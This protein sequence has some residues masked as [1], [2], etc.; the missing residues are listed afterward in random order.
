MQFI[1]ITSRK[2][3]GLICFLACFSEKLKHLRKVK[4]PFK[5]VVGRK[6]SGG[7]LKSFSGRTSFLGRSTS[8]L[9]FI[10]GETEVQ[11]YIVTRLTSANKPVAELALCGAP[12]PWAGTILKALSSFLGLKSILMCENVL[13]QASNCIVA[14][15]HCSIAHA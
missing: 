7:F 2:L 10:N 5:T 8:S 11:H 9:P 14:T 3:L 12:K 1:H 15:I 4:M 6:R 13:A